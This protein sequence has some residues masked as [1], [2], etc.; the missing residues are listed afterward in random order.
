MSGDFPF[1]VLQ[2][3]T[4]L[5]E[6]VVWSWDNC[7]PNRSIAAKVFPGNPGNVEGM[8]IKAPRVSLTGCLPDH[9]EHG[10]N[11]TVYEVL[12]P[13][14]MYGYGTFTM[15]GR[16]YQPFRAAERKRYGR[17]L[18]RIAEAAYRAAQTATEYP[19]LMEFNFNWEGPYAEG[20]GI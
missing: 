3:D 5:P 1:P 9:M 20:Q 19:S 10:R 8:P 13:I 18:E 4:P 2:L 11:C 7:R 12:I 14:D 17:L 6:P 15:G 16:H